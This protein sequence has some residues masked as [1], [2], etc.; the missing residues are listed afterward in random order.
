MGDANLLHQVFFNI[1][2]NA[3]QAM[4]GT[5]GDIQ[6]R[7]SQYD[8]GRGIE[9]T[10]SDTGPGIPK[11]KLK[12]IFEPFFTTKDQGTGLGLALCNEFITR[13]KGSMD[14]QSV[15]GRS[16]TFIIRLPALEK[17][18]NQPKSAENY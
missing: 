17:M 10:I 4:E 12:L 1:I 14:V 16:T 6:I 3:R 5:G 11:S 7:A 2:N 8:N 13:H 15:L 9:V 18:R